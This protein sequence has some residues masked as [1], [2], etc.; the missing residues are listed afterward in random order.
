MRR[1]LISAPLSLLFT[2][3]PAMAQEQPLFVP[4]P[5][6]G[7]AHIVLSG[8]YVGKQVRLSRNGK[9]IV[10]RRFTSPPGSN[11]RLPIFTDRFDMWVQV[12]IEGCPTAVEVRV[13]VEPARSTSLIF[14][15]CSVRALLPE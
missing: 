14:D 13:P 5:G 11:N 4:A 9:V 8:D 6:W 12:E 3:A 7:T 2:W 10:D 15:G 1:L